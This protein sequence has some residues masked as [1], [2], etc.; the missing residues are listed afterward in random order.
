MFP[1]RPMLFYHLINTISIKQQYYFNQKKK[2]N[3]GKQ[4]DKHGV[5]S[6]KDWKHK[7]DSYT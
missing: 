4:P 1:F 6:A 5:S 3:R 2:K 7:F